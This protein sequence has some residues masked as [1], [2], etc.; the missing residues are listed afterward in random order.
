LTRGPKIATLADELETPYAGNAAL[1]EA[2]CEE[3][4]ARH[5]ERREWLGARQA[6]LRERA[7]LNLSFLEEIAPYS[8]AFA[9]C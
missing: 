5:Q 4:L 2:A 3:T 1:V 9:R 7:R 8:G 6:A